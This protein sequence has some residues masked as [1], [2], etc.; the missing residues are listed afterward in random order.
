MICPLCGST[1]DESRQDCESMCPLGKISHCN[2]VCC[3]HC[4]Y[5]MVDE[6]KSGVARL[7]R[8]VLK[9][10]DAGSSGGGPADGGHR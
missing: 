10:G 7:L 6:R 1:F 8:R 5:E 3:P 9:S 2:L 4:G